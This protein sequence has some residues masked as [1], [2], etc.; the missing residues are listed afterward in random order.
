MNTLDIGVSYGLAGV[1]AVLTYRIGA[2]WR[3][4]YVAAVLAFFASRFS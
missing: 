2:P 1:I 4:L 3:Y